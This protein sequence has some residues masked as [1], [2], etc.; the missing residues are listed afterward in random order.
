LDSRASAKKIPVG[1]NGKKYR[2][3]TKK[4]EKKHY[5]PSSRGG[6]NEK[7]DRKIAKK[8]PKNST[9]K[10]LYYICIM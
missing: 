6:G 5:Q 9:F 4:T 10:P 8:H 3:I 1:V 7:K 2:R